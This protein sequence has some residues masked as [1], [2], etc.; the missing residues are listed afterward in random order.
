MTYNPY[1]TLPIRVE[2]LRQFRRRRTLV[3]FGILL[4][5]P[6]VLVAAFKIGGGPTGEGVPSLVDVATASGLNFTAFT[7]FVSVGFLLVVAV[8]LF[9][10]D[11]VASEA[12]WSSL[13]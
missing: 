1:R 10:G 9:C 3:A 12:N 4:V 13:R 7:L 6:W 2:A 8:A 11:T 5:L